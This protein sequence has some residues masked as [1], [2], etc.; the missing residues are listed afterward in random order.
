MFF[1]DQRVVLIFFQDN[2]QLH[3]DCR[4]QPSKSHQVNIYFIQQQ[5]LFVLAH[6]QFYKKYI[7]II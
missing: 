5:Q 1:L 7:N 2:P 3:Y 6:L 4:A